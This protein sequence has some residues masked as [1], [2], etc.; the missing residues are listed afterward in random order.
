SKHAPEYNIL[1]QILMGK[2]KRITV[3]I[4]RLYMIQFSVSNV[5]WCMFAQGDKLQTQIKA[6]IG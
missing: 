5:F 1:Q 2:P 6:V 3:R 4:L